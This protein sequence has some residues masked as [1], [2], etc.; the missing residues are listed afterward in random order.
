MVF[1]GQSKV[2]GEWG[3]ILRDNLNDTSYP[4]MVKIDHEDIRKFIHMFS[5]H[6]RD[7]EKVSFRVIRT[8]LPDHEANYE[9]VGG[10]L[11]RMTP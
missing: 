1:E 6:Y 4:F 10:A 7:D 8:I 11:R 9:F 5:K 2:D 3:A